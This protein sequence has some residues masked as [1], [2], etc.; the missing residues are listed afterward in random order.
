MT[1]WCAV[2]KAAIIDPSCYIDRALYR[3]DNI[4]VPELRGKLTSIRCGFSSMERP[5]TQQPQHQWRSSLSPRSPPHFQ[6]Y[7]YSLDLIGFLI[8]PCIIISCGGNPKARGYA[9]KPSTMGNFNEVI[10]REVVRIDRTTLEEDHLSRTLPE[11]YQ[12]KRRT[13]DGCCFCH[14]I[15][16]KLMQ[17][18][19]ERS[20][21][22]KFVFS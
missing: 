7:W 8:N 17:L 4:F 2:G 11:K 13:H 15:L 18:M 16:T 14:F 21:V 10:C 20:D 5:P 19:N 22:N 1:A 3:D 6:V 9:H 12:W